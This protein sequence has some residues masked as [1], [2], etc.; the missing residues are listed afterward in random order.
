MSSYS[1]AAEGW[2]VDGDGADAY[3]RYLGRAFVPWARRLVDQAEVQ[4]G[5]RVLDVACGTGVAARQA[6][7]RVGPTGQVAGLDINDDML[8]VARTTAAAVA[9]A[10]EWRQGNVASLPFPAAELRC[11]G[12]PAGVPVLRRPR[13]RRAG[14]RPRGEEGRT[15]GRQRVPAD[16][17]RADLRRAG[18]P[19]APSCGQRRGRHDA[20][21]LCAVDHR[22]VPRAVHRGRM[23]VRAGDSIEVWPLR[24][25]SSDE[26]LRQEASS[27]PLAGRSARWN[28]NGATLCVAI[29]PRLSPIKWTTTASLVRFRCTSAS[30][31]G[32]VRRA[33]APDAFIDLNRTSTRCVLI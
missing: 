31:T 32:D 5:D 1:P 15:P 2:Q 13:R 18:R 30:P 22:G 17:L 4:P 23:D 25:P 26:F 16:P 11:R 28:P 3:E 29:L 20:I 6:A 9:P 24:Y 14:D 10:I 7:A 19:A 27:S 8:R 33:G 12:L 21:A